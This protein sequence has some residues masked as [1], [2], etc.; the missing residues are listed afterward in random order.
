MSQSSITWHRSKGSD[1]LR[2]ER[3]AT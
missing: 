1:A 2:P 3:W